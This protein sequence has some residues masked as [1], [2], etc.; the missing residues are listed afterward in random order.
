MYK[1]LYSAFK[2]WYHGGRIFFYSDPHF[3]DPEMVYLRKNYIGDEEQVNRINKKIGKND[4]IIF[5][6]D[7]GNPEYI[8][9]VRGYKVLV[10]GNH[11]SGDSNYKRTVNLDENYNVISDNH[12]FDEIYD[13]ELAISPNIILSHEPIPVLSCNINIHGHDHSNWGKD[14]IIEMKDGEPR[15]KEA[16]TPHHFNMCAEHIDYTP[17]SLDEILS[18]VRIKDLTDIHRITIDNAILKK[19]KRNK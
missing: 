14:L 7:I 3:S 18:Q 11:D 1:K 15:L 12:L 8:K 6:G 13:G 10:K 9:K 17:I 4:T 2:H 16:S 5:L 19:E